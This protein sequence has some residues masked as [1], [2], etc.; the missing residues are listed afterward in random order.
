MVFA[1]LAKIN[2]YY[3]VDGKMLLLESKKWIPD[4]EGQPNMDGSSYNLGGSYELI[5]ANGLKQTVPAQTQLKVYSFF[6]GGK[7]KSKTKRISRRRKTHGRRRR[8]KTR[9]LR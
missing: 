8:R 9:Y 1:S 7:R 6:S 2:E 3:V 4:V 5:W